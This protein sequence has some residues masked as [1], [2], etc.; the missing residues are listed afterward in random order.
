MK[1]GLSVT[2]LLSM[3]KK[4]FEF[5]DEWYDA[6]G[7][8]GIHGIWFM[9]GNSSSGKTSFSLQLAKYL[10][11]FDR[12]VFDSL[13]EEF[14]ATLQNACKRINMQEVSN[15]LLF[16][17]ESIEAL[18]ERLSRK[19]APGIAFVDSFQYS[20]LNYKQY[21]EFKE[22]HRNKLII[23]ISHADGKSPS[24]RAAKSVAYDA[25]LKIWVEGYKAISK[26]RYIGE[27]GE[28]VIWDEGA[29]KY[30]GNYY[31]NN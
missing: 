30:W 13:E 20:R 5:T 10:S 18:S 22:K 31:K 24:G 12:V 2:D 3:K 16:V 15:R 11:Q 4:V 1:K 21:I 19:H 8:P 17:H 7:C 6:F 29:N 25:S 9:Y 28:F 27:T 14:E 26:G 23:F